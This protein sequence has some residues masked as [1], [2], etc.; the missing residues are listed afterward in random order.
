M[1]VP[2]FRGPKRVD[3]RYRV[4]RGIQVVA[5]EAVIQ[6]EQAGKGGRKLDL[7]DQWLGRIDFRMENL[8]YDRTC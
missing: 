7:S 5:G 6:R 4:E 3:G 8:V 2:I 1:V